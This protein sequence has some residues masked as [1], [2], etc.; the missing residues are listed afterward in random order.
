MEIVTIGAFAGL[1]GVIVGFSCGCNYSKSIQDKT[2]DLI[3]TMGERIR[4]LEGK[5]PTPGRERYYY[6]EKGM[7]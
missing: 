3:Y 4:F 6:C 1:L 2:M 5:P 7:P